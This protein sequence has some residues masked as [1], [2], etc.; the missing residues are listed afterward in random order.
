MQQL[1]ILS[2][3]IKRLDE[4][5]TLTIATELAHKHAENIFPGNEIS[6]KNF[7]ILAKT[8]SAYRFPIPYLSHFFDCEFLDRR[9]HD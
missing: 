2:L 4:T 3:K 6:I 7:N 1:Y 5:V 8:S 9:A